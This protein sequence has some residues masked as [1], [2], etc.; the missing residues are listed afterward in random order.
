MKIKVLMAQS[1]KMVPITC[2][3]FSMCKYTQSKLVVNIRSKSIDPKDI[4]LTKIDY[5]SKKLWKEHEQ[6]NK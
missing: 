2:W 6:D 1:S 3:L 4:V 5:Q